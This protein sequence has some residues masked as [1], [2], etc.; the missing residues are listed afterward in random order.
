VSRRRGAYEC[1][2]CSLRF[3]FVLR[4]GRWGAGMSLMRDR[5]TMDRCTLDSEVNVG[6][7][8]RRV[9]DTVPHI[10][11]KE[12]EPS[13]RRWKRGLERRSSGRPRGCPSDRLW[14]TSSI[15]PT[16]RS[17]AGGR[18]GVESLPPL[19][20]NHA[21]SFQPQAPGLETRAG[22]TCTY[23]VATALYAADPVVHSSP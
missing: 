23:H 13:F 21:P 19:I 9:E 3:E 20:F 8:R 15:P 6:S 5:S 10:I 1:L 2:C 16:E 17:E 14:D 12:G 11:V 22:V 4:C 18:L 7:G